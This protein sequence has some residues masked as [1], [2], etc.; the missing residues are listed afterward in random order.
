M[1]PSTPAAPNT[2]RPV[3]YV[4]LGTFWALVLVICGAGALMLQ[5]LGPVGPAA[6]HVRMTGLIETHTTPMPPPPPAA[7]LAASIP[8]PSPD[9]LEDA[10]TEIA[11]LAGSK[12]PKVADDK[13]TWPAK[14]YAAP[15]D[16]TDLRPH[17]VLVVSGAGRD[18]DLTLKL[19]RETPAAVDVVFSAYMDPKYGPD[20]A[21]AARDTGHECLL[22]IP[23]EPSGRPMADEGQRQLAAGADA[24]QNEDN[25]LWSLS[26][27][28]GCVGATGAADNGMR[29][30]QFVSDPYF[31]SVLEEVTKRGLLYLDPR[32]GSK[33]VT[34]TTLELP[35]L[36]T[37]GR[38]EMLRRTDILIDESPDYIEPLNEADIRKNLQDLE[39]RASPDHPPIGVALNLNPILIDIIQQWANG[40]RAR[41]VSLVPLTDTP[42]IPPPGPPEILGADP[43]N[44]NK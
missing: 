38:T 6:P 34:S 27:L 9:L 18:Q 42:Q 4:T 37:P 15:V 14:Y 31:T 41:G 40:L 36:P 24:D 3:T 23:M 30:D 8:E 12:L 26:R 28:G 43:N 5:A 21:R 10:P 7:K 35:E 39:R 2:K 19:L 29:G 22:S 16:H 25:L 33:F 11:D 1:A 17:V 32:T 13:H 44:P 20:L